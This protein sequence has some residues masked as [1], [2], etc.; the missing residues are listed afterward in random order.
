MPGGYGTEETDWGSAGTTSPAGSYS[1]PGGNVRQ[2]GSNALADAINIA[3]AAPPQISAS[4]D[5]QNQ[6]NQAIAEENIHRGI[7]KYAGQFPEYDIDQ[8]MGTGFGSVFGASSGSTASSETVQDVLHF[9]I[10]DT[11]NQ[12]EKNKGG[13]LSAQERNQAVDNAMSN[14]YPQID[15]YTEEEFVNLYG[16]ESRGDYI[17]SMASTVPGYAN[18][19]NVPEGHVGIEDFWKVPEPS[20]Q[21]WDSWADPWNEGYYQ[22]EADSMSDL[23]RDY[24][25]SESLADVAARKEERRKAGLGPAG[26]RASEM[27][28]MYD[29]EFAAKANPLHDPGY[30][31]QVTE[32]L[33]PMYAGRELFELART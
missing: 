14:Y 9:M 8:P 11:V 17:A 31:Q 25:F 15:Q 12:W 21:A 13:P 33:D 24:W 22:G 5:L 26:M 30:S 16:E 19:M 28:R 1:A 32:E 20:E 6:A 4:I 7:G 10:E 23:A 27:E 2:E 29:R 18:L 3:N